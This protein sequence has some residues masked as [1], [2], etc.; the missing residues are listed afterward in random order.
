MTIETMSRYGYH[1]DYL[2]GARGAFSGTVT[3]IRMQQPN[4]N[5]RRRTCDKNR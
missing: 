2:S 4:V 3:G 1:P 5:K